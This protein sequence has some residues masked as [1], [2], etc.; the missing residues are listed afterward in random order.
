MTTHSDAI[1]MHCSARIRERFHRVPDQYDIEKM[2]LAIISNNQ[3]CFIRR[4]CGD[5]IKAIVRYQNRWG[6]AVLDKH[7]GLIKTVGVNL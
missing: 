3:D 4:D 1:K 6:V 5:V 2:R 7:T